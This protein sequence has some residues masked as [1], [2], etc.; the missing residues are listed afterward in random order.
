VG[1]APIVAGMM[2]LGTDG[3]H[4]TI[5]PADLPGGLASI[6]KLIMNLRR[7]IKSANLHY[8]RDSRQRTYSL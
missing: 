7:D 3:N 8:T 4:G 1:T 6:I 2:T 5:D